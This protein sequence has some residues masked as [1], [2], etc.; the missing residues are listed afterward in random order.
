MQT[1]QKAAAAIYGWWHPW[2]TFIYTGV[3]C[4]SCGASAFPV[5]CHVSSVLRDGGD[6]DRPVKGRHGIGE[7]PE[8]RDEL[9]R[10]GADVFQVL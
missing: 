2:L 6:H 8:S 7:V 4:G 10:H 3:D 9:V 5:T 1:I